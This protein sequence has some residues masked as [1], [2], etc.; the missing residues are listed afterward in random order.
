MLEESPADTACTC[1]LPRPPAHRLRAEQG[2]GSA[3]LYR[4]AAHDKA[5]CALSFCPGVPG[6][7]ATSSTDKKVRERRVQG[8]GAG[9]R[10]G[11]FDSWL[12]R[13][14]PR[15]R[16]QLLAGQRALR[17]NDCAERGG[18]LCRHSGAFWWF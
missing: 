4:L 5:T 10:R 1:L 15:V 14:P 2:A 7:L 6:Q 12:A 17:S 11:A 13:F 9:L 8:A 3:P 18:I 16:V